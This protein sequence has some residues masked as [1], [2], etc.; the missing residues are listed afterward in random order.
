[1]K[2]PYINSEGGPIL[3][4]DCERVKLWRG[5]AEDGEDYRKLC[6]YLANSR[7]API[8]SNLIAWDFGAGTAELLVAANS[9][10][11]IQFWTDEGM[12]S[13]EL[14]KIDDFIPF[15]FA[16]LQLQIPSHTMILLWAPEDG[17]LIKGF[18]SDAGDPEGDFSMGGVVH[19]EKVSSSLFDVMCFDGEIAGQPCRALKA[20]GRPVIGGDA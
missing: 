13:D 18:H 9:I 7:I 14:Q 6:D 20:I 12:D 11:I 15:Q 4:G 19:F 3:I 8:D 17:R 16:G 2:S 1:M 10:S 5:A